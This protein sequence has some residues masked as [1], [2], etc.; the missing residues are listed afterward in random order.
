[1]HCSVILAQYYPGAFPPT[2]TAAH[3]PFLLLNLDAGSLTP[4]AI[5]SI[6]FLIEINTAVLD[7]EAVCLG[8]S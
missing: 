1:M 4:L 5:T 2:L 8:S 3:P 6:P 7:I